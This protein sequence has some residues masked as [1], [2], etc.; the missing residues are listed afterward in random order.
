VLR[1]FDLNDI[2]QRIDWTPFFLTWEL[3]GKYPAILKHPDF[4]KEAARVF[5]D[6]QTMLDEIIKRKLL[7]ANAV[8]GFYPANSIGD[9]I[10]VYKDEKRGKILTTFHTLRQQQQKHDNKP[11]LALSDFIAP[12]NSGVKDYIGGFAVTAGIG[13]EKLTRQY[14]KDHDDYKS[15]MIKALADRLAE[16]F[17]ERLHELVR[18]KYWG[19]AADEKLS[20]EELIQCKYRG[21]RPAPGYPAQPDHTEKPIL[22]KLLEVEKNTGIKLTESQAM[23]PAASVSGLYFAHPDSKY[24]ALGKITRD[25]VEDYARRKGLSV[26][27]IEKW[28]GSNLGYI[29]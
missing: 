9:D 6:A 27:E 14:E 22:F 1:N 2:A 11:Y 3:K 19:Y 10:D 5:N 20:N 29:V 7:K 13:I 25:Q 26:E 21:I 4:G 24:F 16:A 18:I 28:L 17:A 8:I 23:Y 12:K 15:I